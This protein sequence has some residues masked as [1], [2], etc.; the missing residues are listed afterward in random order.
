MADDQELVLP[1]E[2]G[3]IKIEILSLMEAVSDENLKKIKRLL[4]DTDIY[5]D[6]EKLP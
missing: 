4:P 1:D 3:K 2:L 5:V 6:G